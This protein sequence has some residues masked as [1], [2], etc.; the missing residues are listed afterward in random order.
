MFFMLAAVVAR[1]FPGLTARPARDAPAAFTKVLL[2]IMTVV[3][4]YGLALFFPYMRI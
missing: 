1:T 4:D 2:L 3:L